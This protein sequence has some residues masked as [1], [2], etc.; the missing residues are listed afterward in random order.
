LET[1]ERRVIAPP[2]GEHALHWR[3]LAAWPDGR[4]VLAADSRRV[5]LLTLPAEPRAA[6]I[7]SP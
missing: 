7:P 6:E 3:T 1:G 2:D 5:W 4:Q